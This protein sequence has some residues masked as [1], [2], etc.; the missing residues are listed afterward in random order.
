[1]SMR[2]DIIGKLAEGILA[3]D[4]DTNFGEPRIA[5]VFRYFPQIDE[6]KSEEIPCVV[7]EDNLNSPGPEHNG[8]TRFSTLLNVTALVRG[9]DPADLVTKIELMTEALTKYIYQNPSIHAN[10]LSIMLVEREDIGIFTR[11]NQHIAEVMLAV[12]LLWFDTVGTVATPS[13]SDVFGTQWLDDARDKLVARL[14]LLKTTM[15]SGYD[16]TFSFVHERHVIPDLK[17]NAV[18]V[19]IEGG[20]QEEFGGA[21]TGVSW[22][23]NLVF[24]IRIHAA[25][26]DEIMDDQKVGRLVNSI[27][28][29]LRAQQD[30]TGGYWV[31]GIGDIDTNAIFEESASQGGVFNVEV[32]THVL[33]AQV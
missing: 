30:L 13:G 7:I 18:S 21:A 1:M 17:L 10:V 20:D 27:V 9:L 31:A 5:K 24:S 26:L 15:S 25:Y 12:R 6:L 22:T 8:V 33:H 4:G 2:N 3:L 28:N 23:Y 16:P 11:S 19:G 29:Q 32:I 14:N